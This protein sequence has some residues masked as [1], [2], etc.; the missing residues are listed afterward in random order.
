MLGVCVFTIIPTVSFSKDRNE[1]AV[2][3]SIIFKLSGLEDGTE[4]VDL[5][6]KITEEIT[7]TD[8]ESAKKYARLSRDLAQKIN[9]EIGEMHASNQ[10]GLLL[11]SCDLNYFEAQVA[12]DEGFR[13]AI[14][15]NNQEMQIEF[16]YNL[17]YLSSRLLEFDKA[18]DYYL[19]LEK[20]ALKLKDD[21]LYYD[22][23]AYLAEISLEQG[24]STEAFKRYERVIQRINSSSISQASPEDLIYASTYYYLKNE[25]AKA[26]NFAQAAFVKFNDSENYSAVAFTY[27]VLAEI[28]LQLHNPTKAIA[29]GLE[30]VAL[31]ENKNL[32]KERLDSYKILAEAYQQKNQYKQAFYYLQKEFLLKDSI[33]NNEKSA[34]LLQRRN[35]ADN[36]ISHVEKDRTASIIKANELES[37][38]NRIVIQSGFFLLVL[39][40]GFLF[41]LFMRLKRGNRLNRKLVTQRAELQKLSIVAANI[42]QMVMIV[43][44]ND[45]IEWVNKAFE[46][47]FGYLAS[48]VIQRTPIDILGGPRTNLNDVSEINK[49]I[50]EQKISSESTLIQYSKQGNPYSTRL[51]ITPI[52]NKDAELIRYVVI[53]H[54]ITEEEKVAEQLRELSLVASNT[55]NSIVIFSNKLEVIWVNDGFSQLTGLSS[56]QVVGKGVDDIYVNSAISKAE[57]FQLKALYE[58]NEQFTVE[59]ESVNHLTNQA[60]WISLNVTPILDNE[61][62]LIKYFSVAAD[63][64]EIKK[65]EEQYASLVEG[66]TDIIYE[67]NTKGYFIFVNDVMANTLEYSKKELLGLHFID[68]INEADKHRVF[69]FYQNQL[70]T[71]TVTSYVEFAAH[72]KSGEELWVGQRARLIYQEG[73]SKPKGFSVVTRDITEQ[74]KVQVT[75]QKTYQNT[76]L[77]SEIGMQITT[78][79]SIPEIIYKVYG[80]INEIMDANV[81][82]IA[83]PNKSRTKLVFPS[84]M[85]KGHILENVDFSL[86]DEDRLAVVCFNNSQEIIISDFLS[87]YRNYLKNENYAAPIAGEMS[88]SIIYLPLIIRGETIGVLTVQSLEKQA[89]DQFQVS[90]VKSLAS[91]VA[92]AIDNAALYETMEFKI[93]ERTHEVRKQK[94]ELEVNYINTRLLSEIGQLISSSLDIDKIFDTLY[95]KVMKLMDA[96]IFGIRIYD[97]LSEEIH[98]KYTMERGVRCS[99]FTISMDEMNNYNV[100]C[101]RNKKEVFLNDN[102]NEYHKYV[103]EIEVLQG[104]M[105]NSLIFYP[106]IVE[107]KMIGVITIQSFKYFAY[108]PY[109]L[110]ILK[111]LASYIGT[112]IDN[113]HLYNTLENRVKERTEQLE[114]KNTDITSSINYAKRLQNGI[115]PSKNFMQQLL[116]DSF[117]Y[118]HPKDIVSGDF[119]W[120]DRT[121]S[122]IFFAVVDC[123]GH[124]VPGA[125]MSI[126]GRNLLDQAVNE[127][128]ITMPSQILNFLQVGLSSAFGQTGE[129]KANLFDGMDLALCSYDLQTNILDFAGANNSLYLILDGE[130]IVLRGDKVGIS[131]EYE[132]S[133]SY[134]NIQIEVK[135]GD[136]VYLTS[137]GFPDQ[138]G[139][140]KY[141]KYTYGKMQSFLT[142][143]HQE[144]MD[145][146]YALLKQE[147]QNWQGD[148]DQT[149]DICIMGIRI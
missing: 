101:I 123:T 11:M 63:I 47:K 105:P 120:I 121:H 37:E 145:N 130:M 46:R 141:K 113:A 96:E 133:N 126:I 33:N 135:K 65:L 52:L 7:E 5:L 66:S 144:P 38:N 132:I 44:A 85:E 104:E 90:L 6:L 35:E 61:G 57:K 43:G 131:A 80:N 93:N 99:P 22:V 72:K 92:I 116:P 149:D 112:A 70:Q 54:D 48:E 25:H 50:F 82:G 115:L 139:G 8:C 79:H 18:I 91:F 19:K 21:E 78:I 53:S 114:Q 60:F 73:K 45:R 62:N 83:I 32:N 49:T 59:H 146:Q 71:N 106:M 15:N 134:T 138:F 129:H 142:S 143:I 27:V 69:E 41:L 24:D 137:D 81:F 2:A 107:K 55:N 84:I 3:D 58:S 109:H 39:T 108:Q 51:H 87:E 97:E 147:I 56:E 89:H 28:E 42:E 124:G 128:G 98:F 95:Q 88:H 103:Q 100:W 111:T 74:K 94:E 17:A 140:P 23:Q 67:I 26:L 118:F 117:V 31:A 40:L 148:K 86:D 36:E 136:V 64:T 110:D 4:K 34:R 68:L 75:L 77:L 20:F 12:Y 125:M 14:K 30:G 122:K 13:I 76:K 119:Y 1:Y 16:M 9:Y 29:Y 102:K 10:L 127:K